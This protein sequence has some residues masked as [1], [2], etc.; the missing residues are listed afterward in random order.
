LRT[1]TG[2]NRSHPGQERW[3]VSAVEVGLNR[4]GDVRKDVSVLLTAG[5][6]H[7]EHCLDEATAGSAL[8][9]E[10]QLAP[11]H[12]VTQGPFT[13]IVRRL[14]MIVIQ[15][16]PQRIES[17][18][19]VT[20]H[21]G[22]SAV[23]FQ[24]PRFES[25]V[26]RPPQ[27]T[28]ISSH[29][30]SRD[31]AVAVAV[32]VM[33]QLLR[34]FFQLLADGFRFSADVDQALKVAQQVR[35]AELLFA[36]PIVPAVAVAGDDSRKV[37]SQ[38]LLRNVGG[39]CISDVKQRESFRDRRPQPGFPVGLFGRCFV[40]RHRI[41]ARQG[42]THLF[43]APSQG[44]RSNVL[45]LDRQ[46]G[47]AGNVAQCFQKQG[48]AAFALAEIGHQ[49]CR[50]RDEP[51]TSLSLG[52]TVGQRRSGRDST[53]GTPQPV[54]LV[55]G[56]ERLDLWKFED[57]V[58]V[59]L[60]IVALKILTATP[61]MR[62]FQRDRFGH[63][64]RRNECSLMFGVSFLSAALATGRLAFRFR[65]FGVRMLAGGRH[66]RV[67]RIHPNHPLQFRDFRFERLNPRQQNLNKRPHRRR[68]LR[69]QFRRNRNRSTLLAH[70]E[71][72]RQSRH[73]RKDQ[74]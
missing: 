4:F 68:H 55:L 19:D 51:W 59:W 31:R 67:L 45:V 27:F 40:H 5:F 74:F 66:R 65:L 41:A 46:P 38:K 37:L 47:T 26:H 23:E 53:T 10:R 72:H 54:P 18:K 60:G 11:D 9:T 16:C 62:R 21:S 73:L 29:C 33:K 17:I 22:L 35:P 12:R 71:N 42:V 30:L 49:Q 36:N 14:D 64:F 8:R 43:V 25:V 20:A 1:L 50:E 6:D 69:I 15:K 7:A 70:N 34:A 28:D 52:N 2:R 13:R 56:D 39:T 32:P 3:G 44:F 24:R 63:L 57:L 61:A 58:S 48:R